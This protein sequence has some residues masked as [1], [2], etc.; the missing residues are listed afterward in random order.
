[1]GILERAPVIWGKRLAA[2]LCRVEEEARGAMALHPSFNSA[3]EGYAVIDEE[4]DELWDE[5]KRRQKDPVRMEA[6][7]VQV[8]AMAVRFVVDVCSTAPAPAPEPELNVWTRGALD[9]IGEGVL[10][11]PP[12]D[13][14][15]LGLNLETAR[16]TAADAPIVKASN[17]GGGAQGMAPSPRSEPRDVVD[18]L[19]NLIEFSEYHLI[20]SPGH[21]ASEHGRLLGWCRAALYMH[22][23]AASG[24]AEGE[25]PQRGPRPETPAD[26]D[27]LPTDRNAPVRSGGR[28]LHPDNSGD[29]GSSL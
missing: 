20:L 27:H 14:E 11:A 12:P 1:M 3:H 9:R 29:P 15:K 21:I 26:G 4:V 23:M 8:A 6:E 7:A 10:L 5:V 13:I 16:S 2:V 19:R 17:G 22:D 28:R 18:A 25:T 24:A